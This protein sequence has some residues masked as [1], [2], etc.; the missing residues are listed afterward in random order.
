[1]RWY[2]GTPRALQGPGMLAS[3]ET[4]IFLSIQK[5]PGLLPENSV[6]VSS[7]LSSAGNGLTCPF[8]SGGY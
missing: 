4:R 7:L 1:M 8:F 6:L 3:K 5:N 2:N